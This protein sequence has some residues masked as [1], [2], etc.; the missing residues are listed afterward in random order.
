MSALL[1][2]ARRP[3]GPGQ[4][5]GHDSVPPEGEVE[6]PPDLR[7][8]MCSTPDGRL[9]ISRS[10]RADPRVRAYL[11]RIERLGRTHRLDYVELSVIESAQQANSRPE[12]GVRRAESDMQLV[13]MSIF[14]RA[15]QA[16]ASDIH[17]RVAEGRSTQ[18]LFRV[19]GDLRVVEEH[20]QAFG[21][22]LCSAIYQAMT[23]QS[24]ATFIIGHPQDGRIS[25]TAT[26]P[27]MVSGLRVAT[28]PQVGGHVMVLRL[29]Y[30]DSAQSDDLAELGFSPEHEAAFKRL[31]RR[32]T[33]ININSGP[34]GAGK[35][36]TLQRAL[37]AVIRETAGRKH[38]ITVEDPPEYPIVGA[39]QTPV[40][41]ANSEEE[42]ALAF[43]G[44]IR[45]AMR[46]DPDIIMIGEM[47]DGPSA[48]L[49]VA[50]AMTGHQVWTTLHANSAI[51]I[52]ERLLDLG[53]PIERI[54]NPSVLS[55][56]IA[57][58]LLKRIC[59]H[60]RMPLMSSQACEERGV[61]EVERLAGR[62]GAEADNVFLRGAGCEHCR[63][64]GYVARTAIAE[65]IETDDAFMDHIR[66][67]DR[68]AALRHWREGGGK[69]M[70]DHAFEKAV[71]GEID[72]FDAE[73]EISWT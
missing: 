18:I 40:T 16:R 29:L 67:G 57:Q 71:A 20:T 63:R 69:T 19:L 2:A 56:L 17:I 42:R 39:V 54:A 46:L 43:Q 3:Q 64:T 45:A 1:D 68:G 21:T 10:H 8:L 35:S 22:A 37:T 15:A 55:G 11:A 73:E 31:R 47:R 48:R 23:D 51:D 41:N 30:R 33:G 66:K 58:R 53:V 52:I 27:S 61:A 5:R 4:M 60:C 70:A 32:P 12:Q 49:A 9:L 72:P 65:V 25:N 14:R 7:D 26:L 44:S 59:P 50:A 24:D 62:F 34:T 6:V 13:A 36:T 28:T 38:V